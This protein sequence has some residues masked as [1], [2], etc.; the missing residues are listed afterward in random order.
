MGTIA[1]RRKQAKNEPEEFPHAPKEFEICPDCNSVFFDKSWHHALDEDSRHLVKQKKIKFAICPACRMKKDRVFE[2]E[3][4][5]KISGVNPEVKKEILNALK[6]SNELAMARDPMDRI[7]WTEDK[8][9]EIHVFTSENQLA[10]KMGK[11]LESAFKG[12]KLEVRHSHQED[13]I[14]V[15]WE[16]PSQ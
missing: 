9:N 11:K 8:G 2:G 5:I 13:T 3:L 10:V 6:N 14:R 15:Y 16:P 7:L 1:P 12:G 4:T